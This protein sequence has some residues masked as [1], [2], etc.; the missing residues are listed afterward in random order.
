M[1]CGSDR[2]VRRIHDRLRGGR[3]AVRGVVDGRELAELAARVERLQAVGEAFAHVR[4]A[5]AIARSR[6]LE[7]VCIG[8]G[9]V[10]T[11]V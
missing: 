8:G 9:G 6:V 3:R 11:E 5:P 10:A 4:L 1:T 7:T 2:L